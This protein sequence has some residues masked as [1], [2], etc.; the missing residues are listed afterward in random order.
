MIAVWDSLPVRN[1]ISLQQ[2]AAIKTLER[3]IAQD[4]RDGY[5][6]D[7]LLDEWARLVKL[8]KKGPTA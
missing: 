7:D 3:R 8:V 4:A 2:I 1:L 5:D 6:T